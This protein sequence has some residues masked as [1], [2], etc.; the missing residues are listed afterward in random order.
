MN[1]ETHFLI[2]KFS[3]RLYQKYL[4]FQAVQGMPHCFHGIHGNQLA[5]LGI[6]HEPQLI[7]YRSKGMQLTLELICKISFL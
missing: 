1:K 7:K 4:R 3:Q 2:F 6:V 5:F